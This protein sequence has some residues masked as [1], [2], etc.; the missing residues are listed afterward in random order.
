MSDEKVVH[1]GDFGIAR[2]RRRYFF[3]G[4]ECR[5]RQVQLD[6]HGD[7]VKC[8]KCGVQVSAY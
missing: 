5:H 7:V 8:L 2:K 6:D 3:K 1:I 4:D